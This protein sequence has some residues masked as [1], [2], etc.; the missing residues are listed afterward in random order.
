MSQTEQAAAAPRLDFFPPERYGDGMSV[1][2]IRLGPP[3]GA[4]FKASRFTVEP[5]CA[6]PVD[7]H[8]VHEIWMV[9]KGS[10]E[11]VYD[12]RAV[13]LEAGDVF[14]FEPPKPHLVRN[15]GAGPLAIFSVWWK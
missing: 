15:D 13:R 2:E 7:S 4:P 11:L 14:Y 6:S 12:E 9:A 8:A 5:G 3:A 10:G 1:S